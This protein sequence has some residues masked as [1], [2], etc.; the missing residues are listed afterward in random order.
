MSRT[1]LT[2]AF[3]AAIAFCGSSALAQNN[4]QANTN[5]QGTGGAT[6]SSRFDSDASRF[7]GGSTTE[8]GVVGTGS[9]QA[10]LNTVTNGGA[11]GRGGG[12]VSFGGGLGGFGGGLGGFGGR[13]GFGGFGGGFGQQGQQGQQGQTQIRTRMVLGFLPT[14]PVTRVV[15][16]RCQ[17]RVNGSKRINRVSSISVVM[18]GQTAVLEGTVGSEHD[19]KLV[20]RIVSF[21]PGVRSV[22][23][24]L[25]VGAV[26]EE[27]PAT[28][29]LDAGR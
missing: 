22:E 28:P 1:F 4:S 20:G 18:E 24:R 5:V 8:S 14:I 6:L 9:T 17:E 10:G 15:A 29:S 13:G 16:T 21:E 2:T 11:G 26:P 12:L 27:L 3:V 23:N 19:R 7:T 25:N